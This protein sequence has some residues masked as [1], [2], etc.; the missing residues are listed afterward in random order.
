M[1]PENLKS[2]FPWKERRVLI[3]DRVWYIPDYYDC[4]EEFI[5]PGWEHPDLFGNHNPIRVEY[6]SGNGA[7]AAAKAAADPGSNWVAVERKFERARKVFSKIKNLKL[8]NLMVICGEAYKATKFY[9]PASSVSEVYINF[10]DPWPKRRHSKHRIICP[11]FMD[12]LFRI[13]KPGGKMNLV[14]DDI[15]FSTKSLKVLKAH[16]GFN[17]SYPDPYFVTELPGYGTS[18]FEEL[19]REQGK[20]IRYHQFEKN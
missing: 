1:K 16:S 3:K 6:C 17:S 15:D 14:T 11:L 9:F 4:Y 7:W 12:E 2:P 18:F 10:P 20:T 13:L 5:F 8:N 19:W